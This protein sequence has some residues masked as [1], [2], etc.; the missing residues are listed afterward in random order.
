VLELGPASG[1]LT[2]EF[3]RQG[4]RV[5]CVDVDASTGWDVVPRHDRNYEAYIANRKELVVPKLWKSWW[6]SRKWFSGDAQMSYSGAESIRDLRGKQSFDIGFI[7]SILVHF[8]NPYIVLS[9]MADLC[10]TLV[11][12]EMATKRLEVPGRNL[13]EFLP[14]VSNNNLGSWWLLSE[15]TVTQM[16]QTL[17]FEKVDSYYAQYR[18]WSFKSPSI[19]DDEYIDYKCFTHIYKKMPRENPKFDD[20]L[21]L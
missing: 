17:C 18:R 1:F 12:T 8:A 11:I 21:E 19:S 2:R 15:A 10:D 7:G 3:E 9:Y 6:L 16:M 5:L 14:S 4:A 13:V 20:L